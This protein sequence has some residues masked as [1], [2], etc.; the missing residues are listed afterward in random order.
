MSRSFRVATFN[1]ENLDDRPDQQP[2]LAERIA[3]LR[4]QLMRLRADVLCLQEVN[5]QPKTRKA[6]RR[7][8]ALDDL[9]AQTPYADFERTATQSPSG[10]GVLDV[11]NLVI[12]SRFPITGSRQLQNDLVP[13]PATRHVTAQPPASHDTA[14]SWDRPILTARIELPDGRSLDVF[15][16]HYRAPLAAFVPGQKADHFAWKSVAGWGEGYYLAA[17][18]RAGQAFET[19]LAIEQAF[20]RDDAA[21]VCVA[22][23]FNAT[24][25]EMPLRLVVGAEEDTGNGHL[26]DRALVAVEKSLAPGQRASVIHHGHAQMLDHILVSRSL[27][28]LFRQVEIHNEALGDEV[29]G[30]AGIEQSPSSYHAPVVAEFAL[31]D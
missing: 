23:D 7:L 27:L 6:A 19:R 10:R 28:G 20:D 29:V 21:L 16:V 5:G 31:P 26:A 9:L 14:I 8:T 30:Y 17:V 11:H 24:L 13:A 12:L 18:K 1:L 25:D 4:P 2:S 22:G 3:I 15:N